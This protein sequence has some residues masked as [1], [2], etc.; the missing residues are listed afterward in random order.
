M[1][2]RTKTHYNALDV[3]GHHIHKHESLESFFRK[4]EIF[5]IF[6]GSDVSEKIS[7]KEKWPAKSET[8]E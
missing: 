4:S 3:C 8:E 7:D 5:D 2:A 1:Y 6:L